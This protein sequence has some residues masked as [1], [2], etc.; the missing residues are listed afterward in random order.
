M[1]VCLLQ[2]NAF[3]NTSVKEMSSGTYQEDWLEVAKQ[4]AHSSYVP[5]SSSYI[6]MSYFFYVMPG[7]D[8]LPSLFLGH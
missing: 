8:I 5:I 7:S 6:S 1:C 2:T 4:I 3:V